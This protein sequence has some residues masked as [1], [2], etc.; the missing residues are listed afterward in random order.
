MYAAEGGAAEPGSENIHHFV[1]SR[2]GSSERDR[3]FSTGGTDVVIAHV[4]P[5]QDYLRDRAPHVVEE[6]L[7]DDALEDAELN[8]IA[9]APQRLVKLSAAFIIGDVICND[10]EH[11][12]RS[13]VRGRKSEVRD[14]RRRTTSFMR[15]R[16]LFASVLAAFIRPAVLR[17]C[18]PANSIIRWVTTS[19][20]E[21]GGT[22]RP[23]G[24][25][26]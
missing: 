11:G 4:V 9:K 8:G 19:G 18:R 20:N 10:N 15:A 14:Q 21:G 25:N 5:G 23:S 2:N 6:L 26:V 13:E 1:R 24:L 7:G 16:K 12:Q 17:R 3:L 22:T